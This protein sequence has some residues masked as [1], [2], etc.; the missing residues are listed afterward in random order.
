MGRQTHVHA[1]A[2]PAAR[3][4]EVAA[5]RRPRSG[6]RLQTCSPRAQQPPLLARSPGS[7]GRRRRQGG[8]CAEPRAGLGRRPGSPTYPAPAR[9]PAS[10][11]LFPPRAAF[12]RLPGSSRLHALPIL[13]TNRRL[14]RRPAALSVFPPA[15][16]SRGWEV[17]WRGPGGTR[18]LSPLA[19]GA[20]ASTHPAPVVSASR[21][22][23]LP[24]C[25]PQSCDAV[26]GLHCS[27]S[28]V[29]LTA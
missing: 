7:L 24:P 3:A 5:A 10:A 2:S 16:A 23:S 22:L 1:R 15:R 18:G 8:L 12:G 11:V 25:H 19:C 21:S 13:K 26:S 6:P 28:S 20:G 4:A 17:C 29:E 27:D 14:R 9:A